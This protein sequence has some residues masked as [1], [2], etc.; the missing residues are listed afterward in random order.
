L[1]VIFLEFRH[2]TVRHLPNS[3]EPIRRIYS[4]EEIHQQ[5]PIL[6]TNISNKN[7]LCTGR[8]IHKSQHR[9][10]QQLQV[11]TNIGILKNTAGFIH[12]FGSIMTSFEIKD[13]LDRR[14]Y[15]QALNLFFEIS[16]EQTPGL[17][18]MTGKGIFIE[19]LMKE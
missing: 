6:L 13:C 7:L 16:R 1:F 12:E 11:K 14:S 3:L 8:I 5:P 4:A 18:I 17:R 15:L 2:Y 10:C 9:Q 19:R